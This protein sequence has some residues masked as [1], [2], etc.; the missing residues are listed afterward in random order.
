VE[1]QESQDPLHQLP[2]NGTGTR[3]QVT[4]VPRWLVVASV[5]PSGGG[6]LEGEQ[7]EGFISSKKMVLKHNGQS[8]RRGG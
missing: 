4:C 7:I 5:D 6:R 3:L 1:R 8:D 2:L